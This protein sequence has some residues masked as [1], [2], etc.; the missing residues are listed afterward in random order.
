[1]NEFE[2]MAAQRD[3]LVAQ[4]EALITRAGDSPLEGED[5]DE[6][7]RITAQIEA[8]RTTRARSASGRATRRSGTSRLRP[9][10]SVRSPVSL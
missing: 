7:E 2:H 5:H 4:A 1:M 10:S 8:T 9:R 6:F 3:D